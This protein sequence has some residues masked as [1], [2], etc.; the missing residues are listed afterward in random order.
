MIQKNT[1]AP[2]SKT[3]DASNS[4]V[5]NV[6]ASKDGDKVQS[7][8]SISPDA[9]KEDGDGDGASSNV[10]SDT[11]RPTNV[12]KVQSTS[13]AV[14]DGVNEEKEQDSDSEEEETEEHKA[15]AADE[16]LKN[17]KIVEAAHH[18]KSSSVVPQESVDMI[19]HNVAPSKRR[20]SVM[21]LATV[22][23]NIRVSHAEKIG[24]KDE[25][26]PLEKFRQKHGVTERQS[27]G[28]GGVSDFIFGG[29][30]HS[31]SLDGSTSNIVV[32]FNDSD[33]N[34]STIATKSRANEAT[35]GPDGSAMVD[36]EL[37]HVEKQVS[38]TGAYMDFRSVFFMGRPQ[39]FFK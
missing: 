27:S 9:V 18:A 4:S 35:V 12:L 10:H 11:P 31:S 24:E 15:T 5:T 2:P 34:E 19:T 7:T 14:M 16:F 29:R 23:T 25:M 17:M 3:D 1:L 39:W 21:Q 36:E 32:P 37:G 38:Q 22:T 13:V 26:T 30:N 28:S 8:S 20:N 6:E 33:K